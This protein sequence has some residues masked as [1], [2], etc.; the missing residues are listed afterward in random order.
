MCKVS[1]TSLWH[2]V[3]GP[4]QPLLKLCAT[5]CGSSPWA[6]CPTS[7][8][9]PP[10]HTLPFMFSLS[11]WSQ[12]CQFNHLCYLVSQH[13]IAK[14]LLVSP[15][16][17]MCCRWVWVSIQ[18]EKSRRVKEGVFTNYWLNCIRHLQTF[19]FAPFFRHHLYNFSLPL[20]FELIE[21]QIPLKMKQ[22][23][24]KIKKKRKHLL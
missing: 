14:I 4:M 12:Q 2:I 24:K 20:L 19:F 1:S 7:N 3:M 8:L 16:L 17:F 23:L 9:R 13:T 21:F 5:M 22:T 18:T 15:L 10:L 11:L 6:L